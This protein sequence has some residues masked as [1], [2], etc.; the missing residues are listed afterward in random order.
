MSNVC[1]YCGNIATTKDHVPPR[2]FFP[3]PFLSNLITVP[4]CFECNNRF[5]NDEEYLR[6]VLASALQDRDSEELVTQIW[7][8]KV[9]RALKR[10]EPLIGSIYNSL[11]LV[12]IYDGSTLLGKRMAFTIDMD[13]I[14]RVISK[15]VKGLFFCHVGEPL[16]PNFS[17][18]TALNPEE[19][20]ERYSSLIQASPINTLGNGVL[21][22]RRV[23]AVDDPNCSIWLISFYNN[24]YADFVCMTNRSKENGHG[25]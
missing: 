8:Q 6:T 15:I 5:S 9:E 24:D 22:Y 21:R 10:N 1:I 7:E 4:S 17:V 19:F 18:K 25:V 20:P 13:R 11:Q 16:A 2:S 3:K 12:S 14:E 23:H